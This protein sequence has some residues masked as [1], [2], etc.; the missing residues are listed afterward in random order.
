MNEIVI[1]SGGHV[2]ALSSE[3]SGA[4]YAS[5]RPER[6]LR[7]ERVHI[8]VHIRSWMCRF[9]NY[10]QNNQLQVESIGHFILS[11]LF[12]LP[13]QPFRCYWIGFNHTDTVYHSQLSFKEK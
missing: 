12:D 13:P 6:A 11:L 8:G 3:T 4:V 10:R 2:D 7:E 1:I 5:R 9:V